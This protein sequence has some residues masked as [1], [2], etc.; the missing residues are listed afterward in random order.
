MI[1]TRNYSSRL[2]ERVRLLTLHSTE[3]A[4]TVES[5]GAF[6]QRVTNASYHGAVD[7]NRYESYVDYSYAA[8][9]LRNG[10]QEADG[11]ALCGFAAWSKA[12]WL[13]HPKMLDLSAAWLAERSRARNVP[14][15]HLNYNE[16]VACM[17]Q[18]SHPGGVL[19]HRDYTYATGDGTHTDLGVNFPLN[20][21]VIPKARIIL[22]WLTGAKRQDEDDIVELPPTAHR[23]DRQIPTGVDGRLLLISNTD[24]DKNTTKVWGIY[25]VIDKSPN[26]PTIT[27]M[28]EDP[29]GRV[30]PQWWAFNQPLPAGSTSVVVN[31]LSPEAGM[32][33]K[34]I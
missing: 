19:M 21:V 6:F 11:L 7:D 1:P 17:N 9:H 32:V 33:A 34:V 18:R 27:K 25:A 29:N 5:L 30:F 3:G 4:R 24:G 23:I 20:D 26:P 16:I 14:L 12:D 28:F 8:W 22:A 15:R 2:G 13:R 31:Y 10:N